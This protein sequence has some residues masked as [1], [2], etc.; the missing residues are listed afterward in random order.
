MVS[1]REG[2]EKFGRNLETENPDF[3]RYFA[4]DAQRQ[5]AAQV[6]KPSQVA[7]GNAFAKA[8]GTGSPSLQRKAANI[9]QKMNREI[10]KSTVVVKDNRKDEEPVPPDNIPAVVPAG[11]KEISREKQTPA[12]IPHKSWIDF[13]GKSPPKE[14]IKNG[15]VYRRK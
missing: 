4:E 10:R 5:K 8:F 1:P 7:K 13:E 15:K 9:I 3:D 6:L 11:S 2:R 14:I 12:G